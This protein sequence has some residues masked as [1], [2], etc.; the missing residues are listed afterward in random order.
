MAYQV[1]PSGGHKHINHAPGSLS[2]LQEAP[3]PAKDY[4]QWVE[5]HQGRHATSRTADDYRQ[6][7]DRY[8]SFEDWERKD[9]IANIGGD[10]KQCPETI[11]L[12]M[13]WHLWHCDEDHGRRVAEV[14]GIGLART[15][16][17]PPRPA[18]RC[19]EISITSYR[20][21]AMSRLPVQSVRA[22][23]F[24]EKADAAGHQPGSQPA[25]AG[26]GNH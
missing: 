6:A 24:E 17:L 4:H 15:I 10:L 23:Q 7:D 3:K 18:S 22:L 19:R 8:R 13:V 5:G 26:R 25:R 9:L 16:V 21:T 1:D 14:A 2:G 20:L 12:R 11:Q